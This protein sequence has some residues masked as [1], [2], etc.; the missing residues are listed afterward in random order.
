MPSLTWL[1]IV[2]PWIDDCQPEFPDPELALEDPDG[3]LCAGGNLSPTTLIEAYSKGIFP[4]FSNHDPILWWSP[5]NRC[6]LFPQ[7]IHESKSLRR[8]TKKSTAQITVNTQFKAVMQACAEPRQDDAGT[9]ITEDMISA[10]CHLR[11]LGVGQSIELIQDGQLV[12]GLYGLSLGK[13]FFAESM[14]SRV[15]NASKIL[16][17]NLA[18]RLEKAGVAMI[19]CQVENPHLI[20]MGASIINRQRYLQIL[21]EQI[22]QTP[23]A[24][25]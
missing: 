22:I 10:Y 18:R 14:F 15:P 4:W 6:V 25:L 20:S 8:A 7:D 21:R 3:L 13:V 9:W 5:N 11:D 2:I 19:D 17:V 24:S 16:L 1:F 12:G 23:A